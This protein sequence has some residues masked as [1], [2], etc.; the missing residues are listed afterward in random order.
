M[1]EVT[2]APCS[3]PSLVLS[4]PPA[5]ELPT[6]ELVARLRAD[7]Y[8]PP[9]LPVPV[10]GYCCLNMTLRDRKPPIFTSRWAGMLWACCT[11]LPSVAAHGATMHGPCCFIRRPSLHSAALPTVRPAGT[12]SSAHWNPRAYP[13]WASCVWQTVATWPSSFNGAVVGQPF[14]GSFVWQGRYLCCTLFPAIGLMTLP[15]A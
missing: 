8:R 6:P 4:T 14:V 1:M 3:A 10:L 5:A 15:K 11:W 2:V 9:A 12:A 7:G 13:T